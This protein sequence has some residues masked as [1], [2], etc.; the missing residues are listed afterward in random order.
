MAFFHIKRGLHL[1]KNHYYKN[2]KKFAI[3][4]LF[5]LLCSANIAYADGDL[6]DNYGDQNAYGQQAVS[7]EDFQKALDSKKNWFRNRNKKKKDK[8][9]PKGE[10]FSQSNETETISD[11]AKDVSI[12]L[13]P[14]NLKVNGGVIPVGHYLVEGEKKDGQVFLSFYQGHDLVAKIP[15]IE[16]DDD[17]GEQTINF[18]NLLPHGDYH[19]QIIYG[20]LDFNAYSIIDIA[21]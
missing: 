10:S 8:N 17:F 9:I 2:M 5:I 4:T 20:G 16:T 21:N 14:L 6:W 18:V 12:L 15:A 13:I 7:D 19:V 11:T 1:T 3:L